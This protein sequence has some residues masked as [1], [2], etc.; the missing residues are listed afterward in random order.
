MYIVLVVQSLA[1]Y[2][3]K[4]YRTVLN[5]MQQLSTIV[6]YETNNYDVKLVSF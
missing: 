1:L 6:E 3:V 4:W 2:L 5:L